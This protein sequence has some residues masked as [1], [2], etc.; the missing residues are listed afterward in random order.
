M[1]IIISKPFFLDNFQLKT[2][3]KI[4]EP[5]LEKSENQSRLGFTITIIFIL[6]LKTN[7]ILLAIGLLSVLQQVL[8]EADSELRI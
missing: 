6:A 5:C 2:V 4:V 3:Y 8:R 7:S 1:G